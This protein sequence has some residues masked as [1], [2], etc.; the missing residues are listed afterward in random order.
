MLNLHLLRAC[1]TVALSLAAIAGAPM[2]SAQTPV[3]A[4]LQSSGV[5]VLSRFEGP[6]G[7]TGIVAEAASGQ[8]RVMYI[9]SD[10]P[11]LVHGTLFDARGANL[12]ERHARSVSQSLPAVRSGLDATKRQA[13]LRTMAG[14]RGIEQGRADAPRTVY[15][16][17][18]PQC[19]HCHDLGK[20]L[21]PAIAAGR[22]RV[23]WLPTAVLSDASEVQAA[24]MYAMPAAEAVKS[25]LGDTLP[26]TGTISDDVREHLAR[27]ILALRDSGHG[28]VPLVVAETRDGSDVLVSVGAPSPR[29]LANFVE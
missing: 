21:Q 28:A 11:T 2:L 18:D 20:A 8:R 23:V 9:T 14:L 24:R 16:I 19:P 25:W 12:T 22:V 26:T 3:E 10:G 4:H 6:S 27:N 17:V 29:E 5:K 13:L 7:M 1:C 15:A